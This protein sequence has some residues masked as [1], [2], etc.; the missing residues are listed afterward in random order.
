MK[1]GHK[2][3]ND[4]GYS[5]IILRSQINH[6]QYQCFRSSLNCQISAELG[7]VFRFLSEKDNMLAL[8]FVL[9]NNLELESEWI[10]NI[11]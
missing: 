7:L 4:S 2:S 3:E 9:E 8:A 11:C 6:L 1:G 10:E 5:K